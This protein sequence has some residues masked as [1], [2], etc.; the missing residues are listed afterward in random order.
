MM[1]CAF[2]PSPPMAEQ[3]GSASVGPRERRLREEWKLLLALEKANPGRL[4]NPE[5]RDTEFRVTLSGT[6]ALLP[7][8][9]EDR[10]VSEHQIRICYPVFFPALPIEVYLKDAVVHPNV[11]PVTG[12]A[13]LWERHRVSNTVEHALHKLVAMLGWRLAN[14]AAVHVMQPEAWSRM[15]TEGYSA[16]MRSLLQ[17]GELRGVQHDAGLLPNTPSD[18][19]RRRLS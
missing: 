2:P 10:F 5:W 16:R 1:Y 7:G 14:P 11:H 18:R 3:D 4:G 17:A 19:W 13:C 15:Q 8:G 12:F 6:P 9:T